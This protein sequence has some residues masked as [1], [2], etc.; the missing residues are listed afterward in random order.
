M[1][2]ST[3]GPASGHVWRS[4]TPPSKIG[5]GS[6]EHVIDSYSCSSNQFSVRSSYFIVSLKITCVVGESRGKRRKAGAR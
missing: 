1:F 3:S 4:L 6:G 5:K 2:E